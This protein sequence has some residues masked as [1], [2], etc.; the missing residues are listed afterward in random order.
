VG[1]A[2]RPPTPAPWV[3]LLPVPD[4]DRRRRLIDGVGALALYPQHRDRETKQHRRRADQAVSGKRCALVVSTPASLVE[5]DRT[6]SDPTMRQTR[7]RGSVQGVDWGTRLK[8]SALSEH[9]AKAGLSSWVGAGSP[10]QAGDVAERDDQV[11]GQSEVQGDRDVRRG[12]SD[13]DRDHV[14]DE[15]GPLL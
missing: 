10:D 8:L 9:S 12:Q 11:Q 5:P 13:Q 2:E 3:W 1:L 4:G 15:D 6:V 14:S 7:G